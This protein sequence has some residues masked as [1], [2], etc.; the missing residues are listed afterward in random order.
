MNP[1]MRKAFLT[2]ALIAYGH[3][4]D[5]SDANLEQ[6][7]IALVELLPESEG[8]KANDALFHM[9]ES[10]KAQL[11]LDSILEEGKSK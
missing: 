1:E 10:H 6:V 11:T 5:L 8:A 2:A 4:S 7:L 9:R 3:R